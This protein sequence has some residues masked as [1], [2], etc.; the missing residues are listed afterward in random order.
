MKD[1]ELHF[2]NDRSKVR[3]RCSFVCVP[4]KQHGMGFCR[5][6]AEKDGA[7]I[8]GI[9]QLILGACSQQRRPRHG[10]LTSN[11]ESMGSPWGVSDLAL[12]FRRPEP[13]IA[14]ALTVLSSQSI[15]WL[16]V[17]NGLTTDSPCTHHG[18]TADSPGME[19]KGKEG[20]ERKDMK[21]SVCVSHSEQELPTAEDIYNAYPRKVAR[22]EALKAIRKAMDMKC[23]VCLLQ[24]TTSYTAHR[25]G[26]TSFVPNPST[27]FNQERYNDDPATWKRNESHSHNSSN[28]NQGTFNE[29]TD[30]NKYAN[31]GMVPVVPVPDAK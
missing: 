28:R 19:G 26:D 11:G 31:C 6:M 8:Y 30:P 10:W 22:P 25:N 13:E 7:A 18:V 23:P 20:I 9:W 21:V 14:R 27:W 5:V 17:V 15:N 24:L 12:K 4:N 29:F 2:E 3:D 16:E 1:W